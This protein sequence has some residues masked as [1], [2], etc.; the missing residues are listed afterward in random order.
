MSLLSMEDLRILAEILARSPILARNVAFLLAEKGEKVTI[1]KQDMEFYDLVE[2][3][4]QHGMRPKVA[5]KISREMIQPRNL[6]SWTDAQLLRIRNIGKKYLED[7]HNFI[8]K[9]Y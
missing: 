3:Y 6:P 8:Q 4:I 5:N 7:I 9:I 2:W 1:P